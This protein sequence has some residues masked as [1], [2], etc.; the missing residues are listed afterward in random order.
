MKYETTAAFCL[1]GSVKWIWKTWK[2]DFP[3]KHKAILEKVKELN[4]DHWDFGNADHR[5]I[6]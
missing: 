6:N 5:E 4:A 2:H 1:K 3:S